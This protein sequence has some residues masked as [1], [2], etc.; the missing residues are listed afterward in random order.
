MFILS[1]FGVKETNDLHGLNREVTLTV[2]QLT[3][4]ALYQQY[5]LSKQNANPRV[6][7]LSA[8]TLGLHGPVGSWVSG[9]T[10][11]QG[12]EELGYWKWGV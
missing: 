12:R 2:R 10:F 7:W 1:I 5:S 4:M 8:S 3:H 6:G 9:S 11:I